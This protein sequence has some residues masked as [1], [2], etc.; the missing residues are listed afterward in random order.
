[1]PFVE[2]WGVDVGYKIW[3]AVFSVLPAIP[4]YLLTRQLVPTRQH[5]P[6]LVAGTVVLLDFTHMEMM[7]TGS[8]PLIGFTFIALAIWAMNFLSTTDFKTDH[9]LKIVGV[10]VLFALFV[11]IIPFINQTSAGIAVIMLPAYFFALLWFQKSK[12]DRKQMVILI[13]IFGLA[14]AIIGFMAL[15]WYLKVLPGSGMLKYPG[16][17]LFL[18][19]PFDMSWVQMLISW[20]MGVWVIRKSDDFRIKSMAIIVII[21]GTLTVFL[22]MDE[23]I[24]NIFYRNRYFLAI[25]L[26][27]TIAWAIHRK[28]EPLPLNHD[29][30]LYG[31]IAV[32]VLGA[33]L[34]NVWMFDRQASY[35]DMVL[36]ATLTA[37]E[38]I[39]HDPE[40]RSI[41]TNTYSL[42]HWIAAIN[43]VETHHTWN[44]PPP[45]M[46]EETDKR[47]RC[48]FGWVP[49][50]DQADAASKLKAGYVLIDT[51]FPDYND[52]ALPIFGAPE[53]I[54]D[55]LET[56]ESLELMYQAD[57]TK[58]YRIR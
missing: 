3:S 38:M 22:S 45:I 13:G 26:A 10:G 32:I 58:L 21:A 53:E 31:A 11:G 42:A 7:V 15:P 17:V 34:G 6:A 37:M 19:G 2:I 27:I 24:I 48:V 36:P 12:A 40:E 50:C 23:T 52:R 56:Q 16:P 28:W 20:F 8:L 30:V 29:P 25:P 51:R 14:G 18:S 39:D 54:W 4:V 55:T 35:S 44:N 49:E 43:L 9:P 1:M 5:W 41:I 47:V 57:S 46:W 33:V